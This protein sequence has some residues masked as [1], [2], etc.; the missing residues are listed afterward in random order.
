MKNSDLE[1]LNTLV[2]WMESGHGV[3]LVT[4]VKC[5]GSAPRPNG[6][7][8]AI[9]DDGMIVGSVSGGC[10]EKELSTL[11]RRNNYSQLIRHQV[12]TEQARRFGLPCGGE[13]ELVFEKVNTSGEIK[14]IISAL[15]QRRRLCRTIDL[16]TGATELRPAGRDQE[17]GFDGERVQKVFGPSWRLLLIGAGELSRFVAEFGLA[18]DYEVLV[19]EPR[20]HFAASWKVDGARIV[21]RSPDDAVAALSSDPRSGVLALT[22]DPNLDDLALAEALVSEA[23]YIGVLGSR[24]NNLK[25]RQRLTEVFDI[26]AKQLDRLHGPVGLDIGSRSAAEIAVSILAEVTAV[27]NNIKLTSSK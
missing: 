19:C 16:A 17:F 7:M 27:R 18:L 11:L 1:V 6:S 24:K 22:H 2:G 26:N 25:R 20:E 8:V 9:R 15:G 13:L 5:W 3:D 21:A 23:F 14:N 12:T 10:I 4:L